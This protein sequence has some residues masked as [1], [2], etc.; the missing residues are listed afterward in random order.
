MRHRFRSLSAT[1]LGL[2]TA[3]ATA[4]ST[5]SPSAPEDVQARWL[6]QDVV[7]CEQGEAAA[8]ERVAERYADFETGK[9]D[10]GRAVGFYERACDQKL[11]SSCVKLAR[12][13]AT[14]KLVRPDAPRARTLFASACDEGD[15]DS[16][17]ELAVLYVNGD[18]GRRDAAA[19]VPLLEKACAHEQ[20][21]ACDALEELERQRLIRPDLGRFG[22]GSPPHGL[23]LATSRSPWV[24][25]LHKIFPEHLATPFPY[26]AA[27]LPVTPSELSRFTDV[28]VERDGEAL[29]LTGRLTVAP[30]AP[31]LTI[32]TRA[33]NPGHYRRWLMG[34]V[35]A[36]DGRLVWTA[37]AASVGPEFSEAGGVRNTPFSI[38]GPAP[39]TGLA[40]ATLVLV[41]SGDPIAVSA[42]DRGGI[43]VLGSFGKRL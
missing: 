14:G 37:E 25:R 34:F 32:G 18:G 39:T 42:L 28:R 36:R 26:L 30:L 22:A 35:V 31:P 29:S 15:V 11:R 43:V 21:R 41:L 8:C 5:P 10:G 17:Y 9:Q 27:E 16:C 12:L 38:R 19:A 20:S 40:G 23:T 24:M 1:W 4:T 6:H 3:C 7:S 33:P 13:L 2:V